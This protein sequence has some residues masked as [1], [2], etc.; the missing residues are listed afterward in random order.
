MP[1]PV[2]GRRQRRALAHAENPEEL[3]KLQVRVPARLRSKL[4]TAAAAVDMSASAYL[5]QLLEQ[6]PMPDA[7]TSL[8][9]AESA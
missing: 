6:A 2:R 9:L 5:E 8:P 4:H 3:V 1:G 7:Q